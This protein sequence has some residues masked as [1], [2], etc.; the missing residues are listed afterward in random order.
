MGTW[1]PGPVGRTNPDTETVVAQRDHEEVSQ[2]IPWS[3]MRPH[4]RHSR[5]SASLTEDI[6]TTRN[7]WPWKVHSYPASLEIISPNL[8]ILCSEVI[9][10]ICIGKQWLYDHLMHVNILKRVKI[11]YKTEEQYL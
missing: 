3:M 4:Q 10:F 2:R 6:I 8:K 9:G 11:F 1:P 7:M 5:S